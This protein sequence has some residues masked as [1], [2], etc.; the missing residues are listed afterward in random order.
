MVGPIQHHLELVE[1]GPEV[2][3]GVEARPTEEQLGHVRMQAGTLEDECPEE[4]EQ[5]R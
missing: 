3:A 4:R 1:Q 2:V 5:R